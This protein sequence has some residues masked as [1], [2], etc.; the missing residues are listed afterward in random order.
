MPGP[1]RPW[2]LHWGRICHSRLTNLD[3]VAATRVIVAEGAQAI[4]QPITGDDG[5]GDEAFT[6]ELALIVWPG[7]F[8][9][10]AG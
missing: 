2:R 7:A 10:P 6:R 4:V 1:I 5:A 8:R 3:P 9:R